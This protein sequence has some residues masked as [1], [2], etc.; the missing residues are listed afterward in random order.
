MTN[1]THCQRKAQLFLCGT[2]HNE[3]RNLL[4][5]LTQ[6]QQLAGQHR[7]P[8]YLHY[9]ED[10]ALG[11]T[12]LGV[13]VRHSTDYTTPLPY[14]RNASQLLDDFQTFLSGIVNQLCTAKGALPPFK[15]GK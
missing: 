9:L 14:N 7:E 5:G 8:G 13:S 2:C 12:R 11:Q 3:L 15:E 10:A 4:D 6:G 1:C